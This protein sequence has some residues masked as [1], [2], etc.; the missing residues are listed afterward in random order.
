MA[1]RREPLEVLTVEEDV[2]T[3]AVRSDVFSRVGDIKEVELPEE[4]SEVEKGDE[5]ITL[6]GEDDELHLRSPE[7][8]CFGS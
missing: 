2:L 8:Y 5:L 7:W 6:V 4:G 3:V 1:D